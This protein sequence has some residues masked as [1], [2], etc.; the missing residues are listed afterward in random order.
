MDEIMSMVDDWGPDHPDPIKIQFLPND[1]LGDLSFL[2][3]GVGDGETDLLAIS[4]VTDIATESGR[5]ALG[6]LIGLGRAASRLSQPKRSHLKTHVTL[7]DI[8]PAIMARNLLLFM[9]IDILV[10]DTLGALDR[11][12]LQATIVYVFIG[13]I[14]P[15]YCEKR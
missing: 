11:L 13:W 10:Q 3:G 9:M 4:I 8:H 2:I 7:L 14:M 12:E 1:R 5:H 6:T 15:S